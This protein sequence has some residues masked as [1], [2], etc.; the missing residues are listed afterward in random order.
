MNNTSLDDIEFK[1]LV[2]EIYN[3]VAPIK[4]ETGTPGGCANCKAQ[5]KENSESTGQIVLTNALMTRFKQKLIHE[6][7]EIDDDVLGSM[8]REEVER[9]LKRN[10]HWRITDVSS[11][12]SSSQYPKVLP[13]FRAVCN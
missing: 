1:N 5:A 10:L 2:G 12:S 13:I 11:D 8:E 6:N 7:R 3:F 4:Q 9:F